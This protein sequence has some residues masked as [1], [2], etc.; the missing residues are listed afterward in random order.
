MNDFKY[1]DTPEMAMLR[2]GVKLSTIGIALYYVLSYNLIFIYYVK[3]E[4]PAI[5]VLVVI[6]FLLIFAALFFNKS[7]YATLLALLAMLNSSFTIVA[8]GD[9]PDLKATASTAIFL[10]AIAGI[11]SLPRKWIFG[12]ITLNTAFLG[13]TVLA[14]G[15]P[16][17]Y[18]GVDLPVRTFSIVQLLVVCTLVLRNWFPL[19][20]LVRARDI[21]NRR[22]SE[23]RDSAIQLQERTRKWRE[24]LVHTHE[25]VLNDIRSV[26]DS[27][28]V[29]YELLGQQIKA[30]KRNTTP[31]DTSSHNFS[32]L[33]AQVQD[34]VAI[35]ID[36]NISG[37]G[38]EIPQYL[39]SAL[40]SVIIEICRNFERHAGATKISSKAS[41]LYGI[42][43]IEIF[44][45][46]K[47]STNEFESGIGQG[48]V[49]KES[50]NEIEGKLFRRLNGAEM[51]ITLN[52]RIFENRSLS[53]LDVSRVLVSTMAVGNAVGG[54]LI[55]LSIIN[56]NI[57]SEK[58]AGI[59]A[60]LLTALAGLAN[61]R[62]QQLGY[63]FLAV[64]TVLS[65]AVV[66][67][68]NLSIQETASLDVLAM[69]CVLTGFAL[70]SI[71]VWSKVR[72]WFFAPGLWF[73]GLVLFRSQIVQDT[74]G[75]AI[76]SVNTGFGIP[77][78]V[79]I[80]WFG[81]R[82]SARRLVDSQNLSDLEIRES[83]AATAVEDL[84]KELDSAINDSTKTLLEV[85]KHK[86]LSNPNKQKL[87]RLDSLIR[88]IIQVDPK[89]SS[90]LSQT[91]LSLVK[92]A[93]AND[94]HIKVLA[95]RDQGLVVDF[96]VELFEQLK[97]IVSSS[98]D[99]KSS[100][101][102]LSNSESSILIIKISA[103]TAKRNDLTSLQNSQY[104]KMKV[105]IEEDGDSRYI[106]LE[107]IA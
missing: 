6:S 63:I 14:V 83:A 73:I 32:D 67:S 27:K 35:E 92:E 20:E 1:I 75:S 40:R 34:S 11:L 64:S 44:H 54:V 10:S 76:A 85:S 106:F 28:N 19:L 38:T 86:N 70:V 30:R 13:V 53:S 88:A 52:K 17:E 31:L 42:L 71:S 45:N 51:S 62:R 80:V 78:F 23:S 97:T 15:I 98:K 18:F 82:I 95:I 48:V 94:V 21:L 46:G 49:I 103:S 107:Q 5:L 100:I 96:P 33:M 16:T 43:R 101:Q 26:L 58:W 22:M 91:A 69:V 99:S 47:D 68:V 36:L 41:L 24:L 104:E 66:T 57:T 102:V 105:R 60:V 87:K 56:S 29:D 37:A 59:S 12:W 39:N 9:N 72:F 89:T 90:G 8:F 79:A 50:L 77:I 81:N 74:S 7:R 2:N 61:W 93:V 4:T 25:T 3:S 65:L 55:P 84:A